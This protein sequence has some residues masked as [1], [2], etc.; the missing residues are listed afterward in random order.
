MH[1]LEITRYKPDDMP[2]LLALS[3]L[4][5]GNSDTGFADH[6]RWKYEQGPDGPAHIILCRDTAAD[7]LIVGKI[8]CLPR[9]AKSGTQT[10]RVGLLTDILVHPDYRGQGIASRMVKA[11]LAE[12]RAAGL[13]FA[14]TVPN[15]LSHDMHTRKL[16][17]PT[18]GRIPLLVKPIDLRGFHPQW[19]NIPLAEPLLALL[20][21]AYRASGWVDRGQRLVRGSTIVIREISH[22]GS[23]LDRFWSRVQSKRP[24]MVER[25]AKYLQWRFGTVPRRVY[26]KWV[27][28]KNGEAQG[29]I[30]ARVMEARDFNYSSGMI[31]D[32]LIADDA[33]GQEA[34]HGL[35][36]TVTEYFQ[37]EGVAISGSLMLPGTHEFRLLQKWGYVVCPSRLEPQP[38][39]IIQEQLQP[40]PP[41]DPSRHIAGWFFT[42]G[43]YDVV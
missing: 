7:R 31:A 38:F 41:H 23:A 12:C 21:A 16:D 2:G 22:F 33:A 35:L 27:A 37:A 42:L 30:V 18:I 1:N 13:T 6:F 4:H 36:S 28:E 11:L 26:R 24:V 32:F 5:Y 39:P 43:D 15:P 17:T 8:F 40:L 10:M 29:Y 9:Q 25:S 3:R 34:G 14:Y 19:A 20:Q